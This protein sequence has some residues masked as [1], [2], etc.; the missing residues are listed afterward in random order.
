[1]MFD[2]RAAMI[3]VCFGLFCGMCV[4]EVRERLNVFGG[5]RE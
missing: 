2:A 5:E 4:D 3:A 1:M